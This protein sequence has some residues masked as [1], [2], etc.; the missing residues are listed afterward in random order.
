M[1]IFFFLA[2]VLIVF[3]IQYRAFLRLHPSNTLNFVK[4]LLL[5]LLAGKLLQTGLPASV[6]M[7]IGG[8][9]MQFG[10]DGFSGMYGT[11]MSDFMS[12]PPSPYITLLLIIA[13]EL[14]AGVSARL[15]LRARPSV[16]EAFQVALA[17]WW[18][19]LVVFVA[20][21]LFI[22]SIVQAMASETKVYEG[23]SKPPPISIYNF[24]A[25][26]MLVYGMPQRVQSAMTAPLGSATKSYWDRNDGRDV[27]LQ[28]VAGAA[29]PWFLLS[30]ILALIVFVNQRAA[31]DRDAKNGS[32][33]VSI[34][35]Q[36]PKVRE[37]L[38]GGLFST[39]AGA[40]S[41]PIAR[42]KLLPWRAK[43]ML[44]FCLVF[45]M[46]GVASLAFQTVYA[47]WNGAIVGVFMVMVFFGFVVLF[48]FL[49]ACI[50][51]ASY[52]GRKR[53]S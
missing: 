15:Y 23:S 47:Q 39:A 1:S 46:L 22:C 9:E 28:D 17:N 53:N 51:L 7:V 19:N 50:A 43:V 40:P 49:V 35:L 25:P 2:I 34:P 6:P 30:A 52:A 13:I 3:A 36:R 45:G 27:Y 8:I 32:T 41:S 16:R 48:L 21:P 11:F 18:A 14:V 24:A 38:L 20:A 44:L 10:G 33:V 4:Y 37:L 5:V 31:A 12:M 26:A 42:L 29:M